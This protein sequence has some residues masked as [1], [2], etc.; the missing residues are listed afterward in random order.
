MWDFAWGWKLADRILWNIHCELFLFGHRY[1]KFFGSLFS[2]EG[3][4]LEVDESRF[5]EW[6]IYSKESV[7]APLIV[8]LD[9]NNFHKLACRCGLAKPFDE[10]FHLV[11][12]ET[13]EDLM[14][15]TGLNI[16]LAHTASDEIS[17]LFLR[18]AHIPFN[19]RIEKILSVLASY[20]SSSLQNR[21]RDRFSY[22]GLI[23]FDARIV[24]VHTRREILEYFSWRCLESFRNFL[25]IYAQSLIGRKESFGMKGEEIVRELRLRGFDIHE[26]PQWQ[27]YGTLIYWRQ[28]EK[29]GY[30]PMT[31][32]EVTVKRRRIFT[33][34]IDPS[35]PERRKLETLLP[36][37]LS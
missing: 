6:E 18:D 36:N 12:V 23:S 8:R 27:R 25:N 30:N 15:K 11:M 4:S 1:A 21:L 26:A 16:S 29:R 5:K 28:V 34:S 10:G 20:A 32:E 9:G 14:T 35:S 33:I 13:A 7:R 2:Y 37:I 31:G 24:K 22:R 19:G 17:L 3:A